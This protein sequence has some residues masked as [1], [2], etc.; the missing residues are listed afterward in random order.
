MKKFLLAMVT[1]LLSIFSHAQFVL[2]PGIGINNTDFSKDGNGKSKAR[3]GWQLGGSIVFGKRFYVEPGLFWVWRNT[4][5]TETGA[6]SDEFEA[7]ISG[8]RIPVA[9]G[10]RLVGQDESKI[11]LRVFAGPSLFFVTGTGDNI[12]KDNLKKANLGF[13][14]GTGID[15]WKFYLD[16]SYDWSMTDVQK[17]NSS[18]DVGKAHALFLTGGL[19]FRF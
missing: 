15:F 16:L 18:V 17:D 4:E 14:L 13:L 6:T 19:R 5:Y 3:T 7:K 8:I 10:L 2:K 1:V 12:N 11:G 9:L